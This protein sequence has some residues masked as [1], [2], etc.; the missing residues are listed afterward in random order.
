MSK[1]I[2]NIE[3]E[4]SA[5]FN[6][7]GSGM[8]SQIG[9]IIASPFFSINFLSIIISYWISGV[10]TTVVSINVPIHENVYGKL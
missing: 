5:I 2:G 9:L 3:V 1:S 8:F 7:D 6:Q 10:S 4:V